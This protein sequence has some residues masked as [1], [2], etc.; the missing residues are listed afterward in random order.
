MVNKR[1]KVK[2]GMMQGRLSPVINNKIQSF[3]WKTWKNEIKKL[4]KL[5]IRFLEWTL[6]YPNL[7]SN[8]LFTNA[9]YIKKIKHV[10]IDTVTCDF[11]SKNQFLSQ[12]I[13][14]VMRILFFLIRYLV[15][16]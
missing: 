9:E 2:I 3:P 4:K 6:D 11:F 5:K 13:S 7:R 12:K 16:R 1:F 8:P 14:F 10:K 15:Q